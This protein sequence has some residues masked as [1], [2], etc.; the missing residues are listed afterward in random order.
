[1]IDKALSFGG[2]PG[3]A[4]LVAGSIVGLSLWLFLVVTR[5]LKEALCVLIAIFP[6]TYYVDRAL[7]ARIYGVD[8]FDQRLGL[9]PVC[10]FTLLCACYLRG[11]LRRP[12]R[13]VGRAIEYTTWLFAVLL[14]VSQF[15]VL[16]PRNALLISIGA[17]WQFVILFYLLISLVRQPRD[18][19]GL[20]NAI[21]VCSLLNILVRVVA[22]GENLIVTLSSSGAGESDTFGA[23]AGRIGSGALGLAVSYAGYLA[24]FVTLGL[25]MFLA[26]KR[27]RYL[28][29]VAAMLVELLNTFTRGGLMVLVLIAAIILFRQTRRTAIVVGVATIVMTLM[30]W[31]VF[32]GYVSLRGFSLNVSEIGNFTLRMELIRLYFRDYYHFSL[33]GR[34]ILNPTMVELASWLVVPVHNGYIEVLDECGPSTFIAFVCVSVTAVYGSWKASRRAWWQKGP[35]FS[36]TVTPFLF[37]AVLEW[38]LFANTTSTSILAYYP[39]EATAIFWI[40]CFL[41]VVFLNQPLGG[42]TVLQRSQHDGVSHETAPVALSVRV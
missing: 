8:T 15:S 34:G 4:L 6:F 13:G 24:I 11:R 3:L 20:I 42:R 2:W 5:R 35:K 7:G 36:A 39:Y 21:F 29:Y 32:Q 30:L 37:V 17:A 33:W 9:M 1:M 41:P 10:L 12:V 14:T 38:I 28:F 40:L 26:T 25:G 19:L 27:R 16:S 22:K 23:E 31:P 18:V